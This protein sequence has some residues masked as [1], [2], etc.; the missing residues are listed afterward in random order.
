MR[1]RKADLR[2]TVIAGVAIAF[3]WRATAHAQQYPYA[4]L[5]LGSDQSVCPNDKNSYGYGINSLGAA[6]A[7]HC[8]YPGKPT[9]WFN[10]TVQHMETIWDFLNSPAEINDSGVSAGVSFLNYFYPYN[11]VPVMW[12]NG[13]AT[14][15]P[16]L[17]GM[18]NG[19]LA[20]NNAGVI[21][22]NSEGLDGVEHVVLWIDG[23]IVDLGYLPGTDGDNSAQDINENG[24][25]VGYT[26][27]DRDAYGFVWRDNVMSILPE[28]VG[29]DGSA[30]YAINDRGLAGGLV[31][32]GVSTPGHAAIWDLDA[33]SFV[34]LNVGSSFYSSAI[35]ALNNVGQAVGYGFLVGNDGTFPDALIS[36]LDGPV[37]ALDNFLPPHSVW[38]LEWANDINDAGQIAGTAVNKRLQTERG[39]LL[40]PVQPTL[41][42]AQPS[43]GKA[44][45]RNT[46]TLTGATPGAR[47]YFVYGTTGGGAVVPGCDL[48]EAAIQIDNAKVIGS[49]IANASGVATL[50][51]NVPLSARN[52]GDILIQA[53]DPQRCVQSQLVVEVFE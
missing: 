27:I 50:S 1:K 29:G 7:M 17:G 22:G 51:A 5:D 25:V 28:P 42:L 37:Q 52:A 10:G 49:A 20:I 47:I 2:N 39:F 36:D 40:T 44:G 19:A 9:V 6:A 18:S 14:V 41:T 11:T 38:K 3:G 16:T 30:A 8:A 21:A 35:Y 26:T 46:L 43:P 34:D 13:A 4:V 24:D 48:Q 15:L 45:Q 53:V 33:W 23:Q 12:V 31:D 32:P